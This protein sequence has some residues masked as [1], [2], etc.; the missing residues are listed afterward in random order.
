MNE[1]SE[2]KNVSEETMRFM[3]GKYLLNEV[4][5]GRD[6]LAFCDGDKA[7]LTIHIHD[8]YYDF[9]VEKDTI[10]VSDM[11]SLEKA[12]SIIMLHMKPN[13]KPFPKE[14]AINSDCG[15]RCDLCVH[16]NGETISEEFRLELKERLK[17]VYEPDIS[18][19]SLYWGENMRLCD[20]CAKG[21]FDGEL[22]PCMP[23]KCAIEK[24][25]TQCMDCVEFK[26]CK[27]QAGYRKGIEARSILADD[28]TWAILP[29][30]EGQYGN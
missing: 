2:L 6:E 8:G 18:G 7:I 3:R 24:G 17:R 21:G 30:V 10:R 19:D 4:G 1:N 16:Y 23:K 27:P 20:G 15:H 29:Y 5:N 28:V 9:N 26:N 14:Q 13:R 25:V 22:N 12:K 11:E